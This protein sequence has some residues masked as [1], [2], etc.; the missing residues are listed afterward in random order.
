MSNE[1]SCFFILCLKIHTMFN[2][3]KIREQGIAD[4]TQHQVK[5]IDT[6]TNSDESSSGKF[7]SISH[8]QSQYRYNTSK[9]NNSR[10]KRSAMIRAFFL[11]QTIY[12]C[13]IVISNQRLSD[14][15]SNGRVILL[16]HLIGVGIGRIIETLI[17]LIHFL[18]LIDIFI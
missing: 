5:N 10:E 2:V 11:Y 16:Q 17:C 18:I 12:I 7:N 8:R 15:L 9:Q 13:S 1:S 6:N 4:Q 3:I 14:I